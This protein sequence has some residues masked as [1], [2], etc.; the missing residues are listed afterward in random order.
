[1]AM[2]DTKGKPKLRLIPKA[3]MEAMARVREYGVEKYGDDDGWLSVD[4][5]EFVDA[6]LRH[7]YKHLDGQDI[8]TESGL[9]HL[10]H[11]LTS[12]S[13]AVATTDLED[14]GFWELIKK[15]QDEADNE[16]TCSIPWDD[17]S[18]S[19]YTTNSEED[20]GDL[21]RKGYCPVAEE[22]KVL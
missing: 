5:T 13:L 19:E 16:N 7:L 6:A 8:D 1:M 14:R 9:P 15:R 21:V 17:D 11:A 22:W 12:L 20:E 4:P 3:A 18:I 2:K 10:D